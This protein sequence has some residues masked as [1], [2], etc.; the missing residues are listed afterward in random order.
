MARPSR[1][2]IYDDLD[3]AITEMRQRWGGLPT[4]DQVSQVWIL[5]HQ[6]D[7]H[8]S[9]AIEGNTLSQAQVDS[10]IDGTRRATGG[11]DL[12]HDVEVMGYSRAAQWVYAQARSDAESG[13]PTE[14]LISLTEVREIHRQIMETAWM[15]RPHPEATGDEGPGSWRRHEIRPFGAGMTPPSFVEIDAQM[16]DWVIETNSLNAA[17][18]TPL[19]ERI[20][21]SHAEFER[22]HPFLDGNGRTGRLLLNLILLRLGYPPAIIHLRQRERYLRAL[23][24]ADGGNYGPL[25]EMLARS[26]TENLYQLLVPILARPWEL[27]PLASLVE[28]DLSLRAL[29]AAAERSRLR[30]VKSPAGRWL[31]TSEWVTDYLESKYDRRKGR[32]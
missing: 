14:G 4:P 27:V 23:H 12:I 10:I 31:S 32:Q 5:W 24:Q 25:G 22:I 28:P 20:A 6:H 8:H 7:T 15:F 26:V 19:L 11:N 29:R 9:T 13:W 30:A 18:E 1:Q 2:K 3:A 17:T 16:L 21:R